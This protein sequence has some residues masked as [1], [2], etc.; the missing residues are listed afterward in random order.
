[1]KS[2][3]NFSSAVLDSLQGR[4]PAPSEPLEK[5]SGDSSE[6]VAAKQKKKPAEQST[7]GEAVSDEKVLSKGKPSGTH[8]RGRKPMPESQ[9]KFQ[10]TLTLSSSIRPSI[11][12]FREK[13]GEDENISLRIS[14][15]VEKNI[16]KILK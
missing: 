1:M 3:I 7:A 10:V 9:K 16:S 14:A 13:Y 5:A 11:D 8:K 4:T 15:Y 12:K 2:K 6:K